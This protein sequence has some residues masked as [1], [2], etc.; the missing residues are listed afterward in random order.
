MNQ[1]VFS[2]TNTMCNM[3]LVKIAIVTVR[4]VSENGVH[5]WLG[6][7]ILFL[8]TKERNVA[9][10]TTMNLLH[11]YVIFHLILPIMITHVLA[12]VSVYTCMYMFMDKI[13]QYG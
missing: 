7:D 13:R 11:F 2:W 6:Y 10:L 8:H 12:Y 1:T 4:T 3:I 5:G 9:I